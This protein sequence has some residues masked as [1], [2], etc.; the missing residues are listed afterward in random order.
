M[1]QHRTPRRSQSHETLRSNYAH[2]GRPLHKPL[3]RVNENSALLSSPGALEG[4]LKTTTETGDIGLFSI[5]S[6]P[7]KTFG[8]PLGGR[9]VMGNRYPAPRHPRRSIDETRAHD[10][11][12]MP[13]SSRDT[14]SEIIS[15]YGSNSQSSVTSTLATASDDPAQR[16]YSM[17]TVGSR[18]L[19]HNKSNATL[20]SQASSAP[21]QRPRSP[22]PYPTR[23]KRPGARPVSPAVT[24]AGIVDY[25]RMVEIDRIS[26]RTGH[27]PLKSSYP[28]ANRRPPP[29]GLRTDTNLSMPSLHGRMLPHMRRNPGPPSVRTASA[30]TVASWNAGNP[31]LR[32][33]GNSSS[34]RTSSLTSVVNMYYRMPPA[35]KMAQ[36][37]PSA[38]PPRYYDY[39]EDFENKQPLPKPH[40]DPSDE[41]VAP[42]PTRGASAQCPLVLREGSEEQLVTVFGAGARL[43]V[44]GDDTEQEDSQAETEPHLL[45]DIDHGTQSDSGRHE[46]EQIQSA[47]VSAPNR[48]QS[49]PAMSGLTLGPRKLT[50]GSDIDLLPS[51]IGRM[52]VDTFRP[53]LDVESKEVPLFSYSKFRQ[54]VTQKTNT[55]SPARQVQVHGGKTPTIRS[56]QGVIL[57]N[58]NAEGTCQN[59]VC[60]DNAV[61]VPSITEASAAAKPSPNEWYSRPGS[62][63]HLLKKSS[64]VQTGFRNYQH[65]VGTADPF[66][67]DDLPAGP[68]A[69]L[70]TSAEDPHNEKHRVNPRSQDGSTRPL[71]PSENHVNIVTEPSTPQKSQNSK[72]RA[73]RDTKS[74]ALSISDSGN[75][76]QRRKKDSNTMVRTQDS[77]R[78][79]ESRRRITPLCS[80]APLVA[81]KPISP[82]RELRVKNSIPQL[83]KALPP[84]PG[85]PGYLP[86]SPPTTLGE[87]DELA[88]EDE[89][90]EILKPYTSLDNLKASKKS[91]L[92]SSLLGKPLPEIQKKLPKIR[93]KSKAPVLD[94]TPSNRDS[95]PWNS[96]SNYPWCN[97]APIM[98][99]ANVGAGDNN[100]ASLKQRLRLR[101]SRTVCGGSPISTVRRHPEARLSE[102]IS[103][104]VGEQPKYLFG[105]SSGVGAAF[106]QVGRKLSHGTDDTTAKHTIANIRADRILQGKPSRNP[107]RAVPKTNAH[108]HVSRRNTNGELT[109]KQS[110]GIKKRLHSLKWLLARDS[111]VKSSNAPTEETEI[112]HRKRQAGLDSTFGLGDIDFDIKSFTPSE[113]FL[114]MSKTQPQFR[115]R[116]KAKISKWMRGTKSALRYPQRETGGVEI[117]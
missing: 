61:V 34:S 49:T 103:R 3:S 67:S 30:A 77:P 86:P 79:D 39:T 47:P 114:S 107:D 19:S 111:H 95:R 6:V 60:E 35:L 90:A 97:D 23:L 31:S 105:F 84:L 15:M 76:S 112:L 80:L 116:L 57:R 96:D 82:V 108:R 78:D 92:S 43:G 58:D 88:D 13:S 27:G 14:T 91:R 115:R 59:Q 24:E 94:S 68:D 29:L 70:Y 71:V 12:K 46:V 56:E 4:M 101:G 89:F 69:R 113:G 62:T 110:R 28:H 11:K 51:Q 102:P 100:R 72:E 54:S 9:N 66:R 52:S 63:S 41:P 36:F 85:Q 18:H 10:R 117:S 81:P 38:P 22:F 20:Q 45:S 83:M 65:Q 8:L 99:L 25:S 37:G 33:M 48:E 98:E 87:D 44:C 2:H 93:I 55:P 42:V 32:D 16:S 5:Q 50:R 53:S 21:L 17:T 104:M 106:R 74:S 7:S 40:S 64:D 73:P 26:L 109:V 75:T 1:E